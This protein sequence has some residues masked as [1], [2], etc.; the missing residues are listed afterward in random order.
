MSIPEREPSAREPSLT[1]G[2]A[3]KEPSELSLKEPVD[4]DASV[5]GREP[6]AREDS[7]S[8]ARSSAVGREGEGDSPNSLGPSEMSMREESGPQPSASTSKGEPSGRKASPHVDKEA[9]SPVKGE[10]PSKSSEEEKQAQKVPSPIDLK[11]VS[12][13]VLAQGSSTTSRQTSFVPQPASTITIKSIT[14][15]TKMA[16]VESSGNRALHGSDA[17]IIDPQTKKKQAVNPILSDNNEPEKVAIVRPNEYVGDR[18]DKKHIMKVDSQ[19]GFKSENQNQPALPEPKK[20]SK[21]GIAERPMAASR[22]PT[23]AEREPGQGR[24]ANDIQ[25]T[26]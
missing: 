25:G 6:S 26:F 1:D 10:M 16:K 5:P 21:K 20:S 9:V 23:P 7:L 12:S 8:G 19:T 11:P 4:K 14:L 17:T 2:K 18:D 22:E 13:T 24:E 15:P 3:E